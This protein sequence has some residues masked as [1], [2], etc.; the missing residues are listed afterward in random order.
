[1]DPH[2]ELVAPHKADRRQWLLNCCSLHREAF[3]NP[4]AQG[5]M[6][7]GESQASYFLKIVCERAQMDSL[8]WLTP[9]PTW[10]LHNTKNFTIREQTRER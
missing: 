3:K 4:D 6:S 10:I 2:I 1:M 8:D 7:G 9:K 5:A